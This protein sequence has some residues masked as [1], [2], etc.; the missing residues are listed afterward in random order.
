MTSPPQWHPAL[1]ADALPAGGAAPARVQGRQIALFRLADG[2]VR[3][4]NNRCPHEGYPLCEGHVDAAGVLTCQWHNW[5]FDLA[6][7]ANL[8]GGDGLRLY[9][10]EQRGDGQVWVDVADEPPARLQARALAA[11]DDAMELDDRPRIAREL[12]RLERDGGSPA[13]AVAHAVLAGHARLRDGMTHAHAVAECWLRLRDELDDPVQRL[14]C[15]TEAVGYL[16]R[17]AMRQ[18][19][20]PYSDATSAWDAARFAAAVEAQD[21]AAALAPL[22]GALQSGVAL[23]ALMP[24]LT[25]VALAHYNDF[26]HTLI[27]LSHLPGLVARLGTASLRPLL[28]AWVRAAVRCTREDL[29]PDF[30]AYAPALRAWPATP[31]AHAATAAD[32]QTLA[33]A[34]EARSVRDT[35]AT[36]VDAA[37]VQPPDQLR[38]ALLVAGAHHLLRFDEAHA[39]RTDNPVADN[40]GW[41]DFSH[42][43][44]FAHALR[45]LLPL[46]SPLW[47]EGLLQM[48]LFLGRNRAYLVPG[49]DS[50]EARRPWAVADGAAFDAACRAQVLDHGLDPDI[51][52]AHLLKTWLA[53]RG[54][55]AGGVAPD[56]AASMRAALRR[57]MAAR[58]KQRHSLRLAHQAL[59]LVGRESG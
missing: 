7:G 25:Q 36:V 18:P 53:V 32:V 46:G 35:L 11:L 41:L 13:Q 23:D 59:A 15:S 17:E 27:Y 39:L 51:F 28:R 29:L 34:F 49:L 6:T 50:A 44:T 19:V 54:E 33:A 9:P 58:F 57:L 42:A 47:R 43:I 1:A 48:A 12:A 10:A 37:A 3:A 31:A 4:C 5:K 40:V 38:E 21:E 16:G 22:Q 52:P 14:A 56:T 45:R 2:S 8:Y 24:T 30:K 20:V 26:G 55:I